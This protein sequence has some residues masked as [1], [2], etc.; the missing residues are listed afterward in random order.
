[1]SI[2]ENKRILHLCLC[3]WFLFYSL[4]V[5]ATIAYM[6]GWFGAIRPIEEFINNCGK[7]Y[8]YSSLVIEGNSYSFDDVTG[9]RENEKSMT[10]VYSVKDSR[11]NNFYNRTHPLDELSL[12]MLKSQPKNKTVADLDISDLSQYPSIYKL[13][14]ST[15]KPLK[16]IWFK[17]YW[18]NDKIKKIFIITTSEPKEYCNDSAKRILNEI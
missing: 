7:N 6:S 4:S 13:F 10:C 16:K 8:F 17:T 11:V 3:C 9:C 18:K 2:K 12:S 15:L 1:M 14:N 5:T